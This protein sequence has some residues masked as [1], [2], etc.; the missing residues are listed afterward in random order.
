[1]P[2]RASTSEASH[3]TARR[4]IG[5]LLFRDRAARLEKRGAALSEFGLERT[6]LICR[7]AKRYPK[8]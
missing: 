7:F 8:L 3:T 5:S 1:M 2:D 4:I 6:E